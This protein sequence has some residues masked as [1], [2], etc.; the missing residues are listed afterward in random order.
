MIIFV[1]GTDSYLAKQAIDQIKQKY[2]AKNPLGSELVELD[3]ESQFNWANLQAVPLFSQFR[4]VIIRRAG[5]MEKS[6][7]EQLASYLAQLPAS[8]VAVVWDQKPLAKDGTLAKILIQ[9]TKRISAQPLIGPSLERFIIKR[10]DLLGQKISTQVSRD[11]INQFGDNLWAITTELASGNQEAST[12]LKP[13]NEERFIFYRLIRQNNWPA[14]AQALQEQYGRGEPI[15]LIIGSLAA[16]IRKELTDTKLKPKLVDLLVDIDLAL[17]VG[18]LDDGSAIALLI[19][20]LS[21][22]SANR[23]KWEEVWGEVI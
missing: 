23:V 11:L 6:N 14:V 15:E 17:K 7:Q 3:E 10:A 18:L 22:T 12:L 8:T 4:L 20:H 5:L 13:N 16:A 21:E 1:E 9:A 2:L 19:A